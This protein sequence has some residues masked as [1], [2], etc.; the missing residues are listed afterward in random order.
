MS[1][2]IKAEIEALDRMRRRTSRLLFSHRVMIVALASGAL[3]E[4]ALRAVR[5]ERRDLYARQR[6]VKALGSWS[7]RLAS[8]APAYA[9]VAGGE[10]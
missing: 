6:A 2:V 8:M 1:D 9:A 4:D 10:A 5:A 7:G 3:P